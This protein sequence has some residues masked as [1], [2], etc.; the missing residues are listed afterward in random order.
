MSLSRVVL[1]KVPGSRYLQRPCRSSCPDRYTE[2]STGRR[3][4]EPT[5]E[6]R[7]VYDAWFDDVSRWIRALGGL[8]ADRDDIVQEVFLVVRRRLK[9]FDGGNVAGWLYRIAAGR[10]AIFAA[11]PGSSTSSRGAARGARR[12]AARRERPGG[13]ARA[14]GGA[15]GAARAPGEDDGR[16]P[17]GVRAVR[18]RRAVGRGDRAHPEHPVNTVGRGCTTRAGN[19]SRWRRNIRRHRRARPNGERTAGWRGRGDERVRRE[20][21]GRGARIHPHRR[22]RRAHAWSKTR[23]G[24]PTC[25]LR[26]R[27]D[28]F[29][30]PNPTGRRRGG[31]SVSSSGW[32]RAPAARAAAAAAGGD[33]AGVVRRR[34]DCQ[35]GPR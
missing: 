23:P 27:S 19:S 26:G 1:M 16:A 17:D 3:G 31:S 8:E 13:G 22:P 21:A 25:R 5:A 2:T 15:A 29:A 12:V 24:A 11:A 32:T 18:D 9:A 10:S 14:Q 7:A 30:A 6:F 4:S 35:R 34:R 28:C 20:S 33:G